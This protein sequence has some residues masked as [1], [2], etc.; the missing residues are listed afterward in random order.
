MT[1]YKTA[2]YRVFGPFEAMDLLYDEYTLF[3]AWTAMGLDWFT[4]AKLATGG[5][6]K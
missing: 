6:Y 2:E 3:D 1:Q 5:M 4:F